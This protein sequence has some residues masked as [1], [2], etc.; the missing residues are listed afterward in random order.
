MRFGTIKKSVSFTRQVFLIFLFVGLLAGSSF[1]G[2]DP[3]PWAF[4]GYR[5][6]SE[7]YL[8]YWLVSGDTLDDIQNFAKG[9]L[10]SEINELWFSKN[11]PRL[12]IDKYEELTSTKCNQFKGKKW[13]KMTHKDKTYVLKERIIQIDTKRI[14]YSLQNI[15]SGGGKE[16]CEY[17][18][19]EGTKSKPPSLR[20]VLYLLTFIPYI[21]EPE[22]KELVI[23][24][25]EM[26]KLLN[27]KK[28]KETLNELKKRYEKV[29]RKTAKWDTGHGIIKFSA[30]G[31]AFIDLEWG[32]GLEGFLTGGKG[33]YEQQSVTFEKPVCIYRAVSLETKISDPK[34]FNKWAN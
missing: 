7:L 12:R 3:I 26:D 2:E 30:E 25:I 27:P 34:V 18:R 4:V 13:E 22:S 19:F 31:F 32:I 21:E 15:S 33:H 16:L 8:K 10:E 20:D 28:Y 1:A 23:S 11:P 29:G 5:N 9:N 14:T 6:V 17:K 24:N